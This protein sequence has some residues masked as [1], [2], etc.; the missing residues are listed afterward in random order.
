[1]A[2]PAFALDLRHAELAFEIL[3]HARVVERMDVARDEHRE[4]A[5]AG[6]IARGRRQEFGLAV[7]D[8]A[9]E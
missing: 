4:R 1:M 9:D 7:P 2:N 6:A 3:Q 8:G 5:H